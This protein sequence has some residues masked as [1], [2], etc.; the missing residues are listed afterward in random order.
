[1]EFFAHE[2]LID[3]ECDCGCDEKIDNVR[4]SE[5]LEDGC[6][7]CSKSY[8]MEYVRIKTAQKLKNGQVVE[9]G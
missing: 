8:E 2:I 5:I 6:P 9:L 4:L 7:V 1:M 3:F